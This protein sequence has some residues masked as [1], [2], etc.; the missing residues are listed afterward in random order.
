MYKHDFIKCYCIYVNK[1]NFYMLTCSISTQPLSLT[2]ISMHPTNKSVRR[3]DSSFRYK[4]LLIRYQKKAYFLSLFY[5]ISFNR[6]CFWLFARSDYLLK[7][8]F[9]DY[10]QHNLKVNQRN[11]FSSIRILATY[12]CFL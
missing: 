5:G 3:N 6:S 7:L 1:P 12:F 8:F 11:N 2:Y 9:C 10:L 4:I